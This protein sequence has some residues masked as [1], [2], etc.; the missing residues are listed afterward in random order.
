MQRQNGEVV[1]STAGGE[2]YQACIPAPLPPSPPIEMSGELLESLAQANHAL[3]RLDGMVQFMPDINPFI[4]HFVRKEALLSSQVEGAQSS[5]TDL[6]LYEMDAVQDDQ[7]EDAEEVANYVVALEQSLQKLREG[8]PI[9][10]TRIRDMHKIL[11]SG[12]RGTNRQAGI[13]RQDQNWLGSASPADAIYVPP[14]PEHLKDCLDQFKAFLVDDT[15]KMPTLIKTGLLHAQFETVNPFMHDNGRVGRLLASL[16]LCQYQ[17]LKEPL[18]YLGLYFKQNQN[19]YENQLQQVRLNGDWEQ[20]L[21]FYLQGIY[22]TANEAIDTVMK[23]TELF[24]TD[25]ERIKKTGRISQSCLK[26]HQILIN[27]GIINIQDASREL[28]INRTTIANCTKH[29][30][31]LEIIREITGYRRNRYFVYDQY[32]NV[33]SEG[34]DPL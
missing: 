27:R 16:L 15:V 33:L 24:N 32:V 31:E 13:I 25:K 20:W 11:A 23:L 5:Y 10:L 19:E 29:L 28:E 2:Q 7:R 8:F 30:L 26:L 34:T 22:F 18:F 21:L 12:S 4:Y 9:S 17:L 1:S 6:L 3:G 14:P